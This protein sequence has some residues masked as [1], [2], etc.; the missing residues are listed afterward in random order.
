VTG[1]RDAL[2]TQVTALTVERDTTVKD[3]DAY[4]AEVDRLS[5][6][7]GK[8]TTPPAGGG[9]G[10]GTQTAEDWLKEQLGK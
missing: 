6:L 8:T 3:R 1:E 7:V 9:G 2:K 4:K 5:K 10:K